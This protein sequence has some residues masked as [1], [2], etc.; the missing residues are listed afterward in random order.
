MKHTRTLKTVSVQ[1]SLYLPNQSVDLYN[2]D[3]DINREYWLTISTIE[4]GDHG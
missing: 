1:D 4:K 3:A 2:G